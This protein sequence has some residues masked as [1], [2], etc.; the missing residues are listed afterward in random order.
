M[1]LV[2]F[3]RAEPLRSQELWVTDGTAAGTGSIEQTI[4]FNHQSSWFDSNGI[5]YYTAFDGLEGMEPRALFTGAAYTPDVWN[6]EVIGLGHPGRPPFSSH[7]FHYV[8]YG[9]LTLFSGWAT[10]FF[11]G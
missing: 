5:L 8:E 2:Y 1:T 6:D 3:N 10:D 11:F 7:A 4:R 9:A